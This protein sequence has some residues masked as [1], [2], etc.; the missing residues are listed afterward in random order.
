MHIAVSTYEQ[1]CAMI[2]RSLGQIMPT[3]CLDGILI[4][5]SHADAKEPLTEGPLCV[6]RKGFLSRVAVHS[7]VSSRKS[8]FKYRLYSTLRRDG[9]LVLL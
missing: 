1:P 9:K 8:S 5:S 2:L 4:R 7:I 3:C 6:I